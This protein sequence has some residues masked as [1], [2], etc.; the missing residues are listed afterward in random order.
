MQLLCI[1]CEYCNDK[2]CPECFD[3]GSDNY[4]DDDIR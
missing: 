1:T 3:D 4:D 2:G